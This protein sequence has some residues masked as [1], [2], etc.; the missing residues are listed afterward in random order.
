ML[1]EIWSNLAGKV[2]DYKKKNFIIINTGF[3]TDTVFL[4]PWIVEIKIII[5]LISNSSNI[6]TKMRFC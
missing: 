6:Y 1:Q 5:P 4:N 3:N 2:G